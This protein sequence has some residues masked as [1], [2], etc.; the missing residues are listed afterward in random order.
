[1]GVA[2]GPAD[3]NPWRLLA[4]DQR[5]ALV[6]FTHV[7]HEATL[8]Q[9]DLIKREFAEGIDGQWAPGLHFAVRP[10]SFASPI[11]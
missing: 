6:A 7:V 1:M 3:G 8:Q 9:I 11:R 2:A 5:A 4:E 10:W